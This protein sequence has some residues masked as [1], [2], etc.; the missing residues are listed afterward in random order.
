MLKNR[1]KTQKQINAEDRQR[2]KRQ[3]KELMEKLTNDGLD[4]ISLGYSINMLP[5]KDDIGYTSME[6]GIHCPACRRLTPVYWMIYAQEPEYTNILGYDYVLREDEV[7][8]VPGKSG[9]R[10]IYVCLDCRLENE[11][12]CFG[13]Q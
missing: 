8:R 3:Y 7:V 11:R 6:I 13:D 5:I 9:A 12:I 1:D 4:L 10:N 2:R